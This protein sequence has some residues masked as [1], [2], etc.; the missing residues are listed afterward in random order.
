[1]NTQQPFS[2]L[3]LCTGNSARSLLAESIL[4][5]LGQGRFKAHSAG[6]HPVG[7]VHPLAL[8]LPHKNRMP[9]EGLRSK[10]WADF[11]APGAAEMDFVFRA[12][13]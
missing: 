8:E 10:G 12:T 7:R 2:V 5:A 13:S 4:N 1:M 3:F 9:T 6:S 11:A